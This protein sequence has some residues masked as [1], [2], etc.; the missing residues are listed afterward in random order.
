L[1]LVFRAAFWMDIERHQ[2]WL[3]RNASLEISERWEAALWK[4]V[5]FIRKN[6]LLGRVRREIGRDD[7]RSW[8]VEGFPRWT[9]FYGVRRDDVILHRVEG[10]QRNLR[11]LEVG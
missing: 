5:F 4:T 10:G 6:P 11:R 8:L 7:I 3:A 1:N 2:L 9:I